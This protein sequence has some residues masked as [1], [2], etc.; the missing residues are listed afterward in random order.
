[1]NTTDLIGPDHILEHREEKAA[2]ITTASGGLFDYIN[3]WRYEIKIEDIALGLANDCRFAGQVKHH[4]ST[5]QH[6]VIVS[7]EVPEEDARWA[8]LHDAPEAFM[9]DLPRP[10]KQILPGYKAIESRVMAAICDQF[11]LPREAPASIKE[12]DRRAYV[13]ERISLCES[14]LHLIDFGRL[15]EP[16]PYRITPLSP[17]G[18]YREFMARFRELFIIDN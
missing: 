13:T 2:T 9:R 6:S 4:Y 10:L 5:A 14:V 18:A 12:H 15:P 16:Y 8:L 1:M 7:Y 17:S 11:N 3:P